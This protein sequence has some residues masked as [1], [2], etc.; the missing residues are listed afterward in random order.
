MEIKSS[1][2]TE[3]DHPVSKY[4]KRYSNRYLKPHTPCSKHYL[5][6]R[7]KKNLVQHS[8]IY[9]LSQVFTSTGKRRLEAGKG[10][11]WHSSDLFTA[12]SAATCK[13]GSDGFFYPLAGLLTVSNSS[14]YSNTLNN[15]TIKTLE[16]HN[17]FFSDKHHE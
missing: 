5:S 4:S 10:T 8:N 12:T 13:N 3:S 1:L 17:G 2:R 7:K 6:T 9:L 16:S 11:G 15:N 14:S